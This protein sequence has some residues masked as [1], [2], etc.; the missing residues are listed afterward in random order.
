MP[1]MSK[2]Q[3]PGIS[4]LPLGHRP[5]DQ[6]IMLDLQYLTSQTYPQRRLLAPVQQEGY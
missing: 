1:D 2:Q 6:A 4:S 3:A 5:F